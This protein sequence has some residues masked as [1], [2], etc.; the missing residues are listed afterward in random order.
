[1]RYSIELWCGEIDTIEEVLDHQ[2]LGHDGVIPNQGIHIVGGALKD[3][4]AYLPKAKQIIYFNNNN[5][6]NEIAENDNRNKLSLY[7]L[8]Q[9]AIFHQQEGI[10]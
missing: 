1:M 4:F 2:V 3:L 8:K 10:K 7:Y 9:D 6:F 5:T